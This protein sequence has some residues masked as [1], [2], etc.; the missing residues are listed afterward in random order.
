[1]RGNFAG[2]RA[3][4]APRN[5]LRQPIATLV[6]FAASTAVEIAVNGGATTMSQCCE[7]ATAGMNAEKNAR[8]SACVLYIFQ[9]PAITGD[10]GHERL[11]EFGVL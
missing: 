3:F 7:F 11:L 5:V 4:L 10:A 1:M 8:V 2:E 9:L 6:P